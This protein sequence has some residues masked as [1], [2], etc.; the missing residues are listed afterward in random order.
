VSV[1][2]QGTFDTLSVT[3]LF[4]LLSTAGKTGA[5]RLEAGEDGAGPVKASVFVIG[6]LCCAVESDEVGGP[7]GSEPELASRLVDVGFS[8]AR[9]PAGSFQFS[10]DESPAF[11]VVAT[12][13]LE[14]AV[15]EI[16]ALLE[17][18]RE[19]E[20]TIPSLEA[21]VR[22]A[23]V[24]RADE[25]VLTASEWGLLVGLVGSPSVRELIARAGLPM[26][27]VCRTVADLVD[28]GAI[29]VGGAGGVP[30]LRLDSGRRGREASTPGALHPIEAI[31][32]YAP[33][34][35]AVTTAVDAIAAVEADDAMA[36][37]EADAVA[38]GLVSRMTKNR[39][40][41]PD[42]F[43]SG[44]DE[45]AADF[46]PATRPDDEVPEVLADSPATEA[47]SAPDDAQQDRGALLRLFSALKE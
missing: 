17:Q 31:E 35:D 33:L 27:E 37:A 1:S 13:R 12:T 41:I 44:P 5:L 32:P 4:G 15:A 23:P 46:D 22:L 26:I 19:I 14:P 47:E 21:R 28:R 20:D 29:E 7:A 3:E 40:A 6:G 8:L 24:L 30:E 9:S 43:A 45:D 34:S 18:W 25:I 16:T 42:A 10:D 38:A 39:R 36:A 2:L 11:D